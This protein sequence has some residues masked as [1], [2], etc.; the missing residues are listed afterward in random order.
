ML[1]LVH[2]LQTGGIICLYSWRGGEF[3][4][5]MVLIEVKYLLLLEEGRNG[6]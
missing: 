3:R 6:I 4:A 2:V 1:V 5:A